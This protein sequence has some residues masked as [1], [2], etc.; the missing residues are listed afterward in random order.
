M[1]DLMLD[2]DQAGELKA[3]FRRGDWT[4]AEIK[5]ACEG[6]SLARFRDV[7]R[8]YAKVVTTQHIIDCDAKLF[9]PNGW[10][11][12]NEDQLVSRIRGQLILDTSKIKLYLSSKQQDG[13]YIEGNKLRKELASDP[14]LN[15]NVLD[16]LLKF[17][18]QHLI[19][20]EW[21]DKYIFFWGTIYRDSDDNLCVRFLCFNDGAWYWGYSWLG[22]GF[23]GSYPAAV[24]AS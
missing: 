18:N 7:V 5:R 10:R 12:E 15:A 8:G 20:E 13:K 21:K 2:V 3:A 9:I 17:E 23:C 6:D 4:N 22:H 16:Y 19:P 24:L 11:V 14:V 1:S